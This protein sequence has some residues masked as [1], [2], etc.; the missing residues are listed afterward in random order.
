MKVISNSGGGATAQNVTVSGS[1]ASLNL[2]FTEN[3]DY[4]AGDTLLTHGWTLSGSNTTNPL[5]VS[6]PGLAL[7][8]YLY[9]SGNS[10]A[11]TTSGE[12]VYNNFTSV[13]ISSGNVYLSFLVNVSA[14][15]T[16]DY[17]IALSS[18]SSQI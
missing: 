5:I 13:G 14:A 12:D 10:V 18:A 15:Q 8:N 2:L 16:G 11:M 1:V 3:F 7:P 17:F 4:P 6:S 9:N